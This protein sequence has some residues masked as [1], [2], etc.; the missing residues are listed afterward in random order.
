MNKKIKDFFI[1][2]GLTIEKDIAMGTIDGVITRFHCFN[3]NRGLTVRCIFVGYLPA[4][5]KALIVDELNKT[6]NLFCFTQTEI[7]IFTQIDRLGIDKMIDEIS[8]MLDIVIPKLK[9]NGILCE[10]YCPFYGTELTDENKY[11][12][13]YNYYRIE[14]SKECRDFLNKQI[15]EDEKIRNEEKDNIGKG[16]LGALIGGVVG[17][18]SVLIF[19]QLNVISSLSAIIAFALGSWLYIK[20][21]GKPNIKMVVIVSIISTIFVLG[22]FYGECVY[23]CNK[24]CIDEGYSYRGISAF[25][26]VIKESENFRKAFRHDILFYILFIVVGILAPIGSYVRA[27]KKAERL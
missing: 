19:Y 8:K 15:D 7:H 27:N 5:K 25:N 3:T 1:G 14:I 13:D 20:F 22:A 2:K 21:G 12:T 26:Y 9:E 24:I 10:G 4:D 17:A 18:V 6:M 16:I 11:T 23:L